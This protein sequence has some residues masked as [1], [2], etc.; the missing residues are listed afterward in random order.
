MIFLA[1]PFLFPI[2]DSGHQLDSGPLDSMYQGAQNK[3]FQVL[4]SL[5]FELLA[6]VNVLVYVGALAVLFLFV[7]MLYSIAQN[8]VFDKDGSPSH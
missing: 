5:G 1:F 7:I 4:L 2:F 3:V 8:K 6:L